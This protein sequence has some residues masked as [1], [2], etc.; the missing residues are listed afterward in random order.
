MYPGTVLIA[1]KVLIGV[2]GEVTGF[3][4]TGST[5]AQMGDGI[6]TIQLHVATP[7]NIL[8]NVWIQNNTGSPYMASLITTDTSTGIVTV[9]T[10]AADDPGTTVGLP[11]GAYMCFT[12]FAQD[13]STL[14]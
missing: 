10:A 9:Y 6:Y 8:A 14:V 3:Q 7:V 2:D 11:V 5:T 4:P 13:P 1:G 12:C